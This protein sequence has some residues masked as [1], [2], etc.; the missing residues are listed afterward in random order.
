[1]FWRKQRHALEIEAEQCANVIQHQLTRLNLA[2]REK[3]ERV[4]VVHRVEFIEPLIATPTEVRIEVD[5]SR[6]PRAVTITDLRQPDVLETLSVACKHPVRA[7][8]KKGKGGGFWFVVELEER[9]TIPRLVK[10]D[11]MKPPEN[12]PALIIPIG[13]GEHKRQQWEDLRKLPHLLIAGATGQGKSVMVNSLLCWLARRLPP[14]QLQMY[15]CDLKGGMELSFYRDLPHTQKLITRNR[16]LPVMLSWLQQEMD[17]R[18]DL[19]AGSARDLDDYNK[20]KDPNQQLPYILV[21]IDEIA[22]AML[23]KEKIRINDEQHGTIASLTESLLADL[24]ARARAT[25]IHLIVSTQRPSVDVVTGL[26]KANFPSRIAFGTSSEI[27]S[28]V[29]IDDGSAAGLDKGR[30]KFRRNMDLLELQ[31]P[32]LADSDVVQHVRKAIAGE[33]LSTGLTPEE[34]ERQTIGQ[35]LHLAETEFAGTFPVKKLVPRSGVSHARIEEIAK[36]LESAGI[37]KKN[38]GPRARSIAVPPG[39]WKKLYPPSVMRH[40]SQQNG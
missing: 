30:M 20:H 9:A 5:M 39:Q 32:F 36:Q 13:I 27:D 31:A 18:T 8:H 22:N 29:I 21:V 1:M 17:R 7:E 14:T 2:Y 40:A 4:D 15:L 25:G 38:F 16:Q 10:F 34:L 11:D 28:R 3:V 23:A 26:I 35:L 6:L 12:A 19:M 24:A 37:L 33:M